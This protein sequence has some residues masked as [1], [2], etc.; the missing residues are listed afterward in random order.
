MRGTTDDFMS[1]TKDIP[2]RT[3]T[4]IIDPTHATYEMYMPAPD[5]SEFLSM[6]IE[7]TKVE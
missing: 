6:R 2:F 3:V 4:T 7:T 5:G 1:G